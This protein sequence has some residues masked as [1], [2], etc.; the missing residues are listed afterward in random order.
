MIADIGV[1][2]LLG[3]GVATGLWTMQRHHEYFSEFTLGDLFRCRLDGWMY[4]LNLISTAVCL[5]DIVLRIGFVSEFGWSV[6]R[7]QRLWLLPHTSYALISIMI[8]CITNALLS[9]DGFCRLCKREW[10]GSDDGT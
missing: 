1:C 4:V 6:S 2:I 3:V 5:V 7:W 9:R 8:H 10:G